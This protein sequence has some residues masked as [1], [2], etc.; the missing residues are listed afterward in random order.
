[1]RLNFAKFVTLSPNWYIVTKIYD[2]K[3]AFLLSHKWRNIGWVL[4]PFAIAFLIAAIVYEYTVPF[5]VFGHPKLSAGDTFD[6]KNNNLTD[7]LSIL[8]TF[9]SL[10]CIAFSKEKVEDEY[11]AAVRLKALQ[12]SV[13]VNY[14]VLVISLFTIYGLSFLYVLYGNLFTILIIFIMVY[15]YYLHL[16]PK[17][18]GGKI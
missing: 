2:M 18:A 6:I 3:N 1:M 14:A 11:V 5:L 17:M 4:L 15:Y 16:K 13:Y 8:F 10:F 12:V 9:I 7:E